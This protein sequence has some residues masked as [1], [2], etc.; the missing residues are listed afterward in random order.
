MIF[1]VHSIVEIILSSSKLLIGSF[2]LGVFLNWYIN[3]GKVTFSRRS[4][5][6]NFLVPS[7]WPHIKI[8][9][10]Y[11]FPITVFINNSKTHQ[12]RVVWSQSDSQISIAPKIRS[13]LEG[14]SAPNKI[15]YYWPSYFI[16]LT[17]FKETMSCK[18]MDQFLFNV[19]VW[20]YYLFRKNARYIIFSFF[21]YNECFLICVCFHAS[22][23]LL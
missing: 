11:C 6:P 12:L 18:Q 10:S 15:K 20:L 2:F 13:C 8:T 4:V 21:Y 7:L 14:F 23:I 9:C 19:L 5:F 17:W 16:S 22:L 3:K 1:G